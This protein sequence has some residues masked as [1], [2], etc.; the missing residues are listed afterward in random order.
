MLPEKIDKA[1]NAFY[2]EI[3]NNGV[4]DRKTTVMLKLTA[5]M[6]HGCQP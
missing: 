1:F 2:D 5:A 4:F 3:K 6:T